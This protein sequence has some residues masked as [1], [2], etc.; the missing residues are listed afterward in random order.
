MSGAPAGDP[1]AT[2]ALA[3]AAGRRFWKA[4][5]SGNDFVFL[6]ARAAGSAPDPLETADA[7]RAL[8]APHLGIGAD[9]V[10]FMTAG[11]QPEA[12][13]AI[14]YYNSDGSRARLCGNASLCAAQ[15]A[16]ELGL[17]A[18]HLEFGL[19][20]DAGRLAARAGDASAG[21]IELPGATSVRPDE[22]DA[23]TNGE[24]RIGFAT[25]GVPHVVV[26]VEDASKVAID[27]RG[28][29]LRRSSPE[30][31]DGANVNFVSAGST[32]DGVRGLRTFERG[33]EGETLACGTGALATAALLT[34]WGLIAPGTP[35][36]LRTASG[37][38]LTV[39]PASGD[40]V[41]LAGEGRI[42]YEGTL[43]HVR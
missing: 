3:H 11:A 17:A 15:M 20:T 5:G 43:R 38:V 35:V 40:R 22:V 10:V 39:H 42:V 34:A 25:V 12:A 27:E 14:R 30:R 28:A 2:D 23:R 1:P 33:V 32:P 37:R 41:I 29:A 8:C 19:I 9:G 21:T 13:A 18:R 16:V 4:S 24:Q 31:P 7:I 36:A 6:D 26:L